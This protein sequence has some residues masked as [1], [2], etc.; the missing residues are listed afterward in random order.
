MVASPL[1]AAASNLRRPPWA[2]SLQLLEIRQ[3]GPSLLPPEEALE[4]PM[5]KRQH[6]P[7]LIPLQPR[8][9]QPSWLLNLASIAAWTWPLRCVQI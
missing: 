6:G 4:V 7:I 1:A 2:A 8:D 5:E 3:H 9:V